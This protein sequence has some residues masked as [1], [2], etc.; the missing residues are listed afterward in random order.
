MEWWVETDLHRQGECF[1]K[2]RS[3]D[4]PR[5]KRNQHKETLAI[6]HRRL[7]SHPISTSL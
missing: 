5:R 4:P 2:A 1:E 6:G 7:L 3:R